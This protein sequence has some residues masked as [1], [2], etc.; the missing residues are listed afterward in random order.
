MACLAECS[1]GIEPGT[2]AGGYIKSILPDKMK[3]KLAIVDTGEAAP[4]PPTPKY[5]I[6]EGHLERWCYSPETCPRQIET[7]F[8]TA[9][10]EI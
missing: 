7:V 6:S 1:E 10:V 8:D 5:Y 2:L 4:P 9:V 3:I